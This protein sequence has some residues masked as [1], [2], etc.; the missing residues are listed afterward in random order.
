M[1]VE[2]F[3]L[4]AMMDGHDAIFLDTSTLCFR[5]SVGMSVEE[6]NAYFRANKDRTFL[7]QVDIPREV[8]EKSIDFNIALAYLLGTES[9]FRVLESVQQEYP[10]AEGIAAKR[11]CL[12]YIRDKLVAPYNASV[13]KLRDALDTRI[14]VPNEEFKSRAERVMQD[15]EAIFDS[16][17]LSKTDKELL[18]FSIIS[19]EDV[20]TVLAS[21]DKNL[22]TAAQTLHRVVRPKCNYGLYTTLRSDKFREAN[23][24]DFK[25]A[26]RHWAKRT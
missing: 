5:V 21:N 15:F 12:C 23:G 17:G 9:A 6:Y 18:A 16:N 3:G 2:D 13:D 20:N 8:L 14:F 4:E 1:P 26:V 11:A 25:I 22:L 10:V 7:R 24:D 19:S